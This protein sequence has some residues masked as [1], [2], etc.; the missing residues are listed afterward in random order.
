MQE[1]LDR[2]WEELTFLK[3]QTRRV[4]SLLKLCEDV[5]GWV[6]GE[7]PGVSTNGREGSETPTDSCPLR[8]L[9]LWGRL[10]VMCSFQTTRDSPGTCLYL[11][12]SLCTTHSA[13]P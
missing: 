10:F 9:S 12:P 13:A 11:T 4:G 5:A 3:T 6:T 1:V 8:R 2:R 7:R